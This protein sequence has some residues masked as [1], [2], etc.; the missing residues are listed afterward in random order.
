MS[1]PCKPS[2]SRLVVSIIYAGGSAL[3]EPAH[4]ASARARLE[5][6]F[7]P[8]DF[9][10]P[11]MEFAFTD[12]YNGEMGGD[13][14]RQFVSF[15][16]LV[17]RETLADIKLFSN[18]I[19]KELCRPDGGRQVNIDPGLL[20]LE[21]FILATAKNFTHRVYLRDGIFADLTLIYSGKKFNAMPWT[22]PDYSSEEIQSI[23]GELR[24][25]LAE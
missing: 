5:E 11:D 13:L 21:N 9:R 22:F 25:R 24:K 17:R 12:Y 20:S 18:E 19:E 2:P 1:E 10:G 15:E 6:K 4:L 8:M 16:R 3:G 23:L 7:G 14:R